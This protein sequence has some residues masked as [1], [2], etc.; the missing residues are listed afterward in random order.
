MAKTPYT[1]L[2]L[3]TQLVEE[4]KVWRLAF[5]NAY[6]KTVSYAEILRIM[7]ASLNHSKPEVVEEMEGILKKHPD[8]LDKMGK[9][10]G[11]D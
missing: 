9:N 3:P 8:L 6:G 4:L 2:N 7:L 5:S 11:N 10:G 1:A